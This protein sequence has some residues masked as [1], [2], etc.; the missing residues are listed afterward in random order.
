[1]GLA[2]DH[3]DLPRPQRTQDEGHPPDSF[4]TFLAPFFDALRARH[5]AEGERPHAYPGTAFRHSMA[6]GCARAI[7]Y[8]AL[9][10]P[11]SNPMD[12]AGL[13]VTQNGTDKHDQIQAVLGSAFPDHFEAEVRVRIPDFNGS[14]NADGVF[15]DPDDDGT[16]PNP[17]RTCWE[18]KNVGG[19]AYKK[20]VGERGEPEGPKSS[21]IIQGALNAKGMDADL[22]VIT[23]LSWEAISVQAAA[24]KKI[25]EEGRFAAQWTFT[26]DE[27]EPIADAEVARVDG[28]L[29]LLDEGTLPARKHPDIP[30]R[31]VIV[32]P[33]IG[34]WQVM[35]EG[36]APVSL[37]TTWACPYCAWQSF[38]A[39]TESG[40]MPVETAV[41]LRQWV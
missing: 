30:P 10:I 40:R 29:A 4:P 24:R 11:A 27:W 34:A 22:L 25:S 26:R 32:D 12:L 36:E 18:H 6:G 21:H 15:D 17:V 9:N 7:A 1:M 5:E 31:A 16:G 23:Y 38:C 19:F 39:L 33:T 20:A 8:H 3:S 2:A 41:E 14:G 28:I 37:G 35:D 13:W